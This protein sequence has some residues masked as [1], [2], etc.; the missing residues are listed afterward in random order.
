MTDSSA[1]VSAKRD[2]QASRVAKILVERIR[3]GLYPIG[4]RI[5]SERVLALEF[6]VSRP[7]IREALST[8]SAL[9]I[10]DVQMGRGSFVT[11][12]PADAALVAETNLQDV[13]NVREILEAG[14]LQLC[15]GGV[16]EGRRKAVAEALERLSKAAADR[17]ETIGPDTA[18]HY[19]II[20]APGSELLSSLWEGLEQRIEETIRISPHGHNMSDSILDLHRR[21]AD[22]VLV[23]STADA[24]DASRELHQQ[25]R[26]FLRKLLG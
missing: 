19:A 2:S 23:E 3:S 15:S 6:E 4:S 26:D 12:V 5:P 21:L 1:A 24:I 13:V 10:L 25:N 17:S 18:L 9:D 14:A 22:G 7:V 20:K 16:P 11:A 8:V